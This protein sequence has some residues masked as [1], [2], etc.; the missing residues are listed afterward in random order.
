MKLMIGGNN[1]LIYPGIG[2]GAIVAKANKI[3]DKMLVR[4]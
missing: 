1:A 3:T 4:L 2:F